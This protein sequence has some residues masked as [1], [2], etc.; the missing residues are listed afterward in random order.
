M[1]SHSFHWALEFAYRSFVPTLLVIDHVPLNRQQGY[2]H[3]KS[4]RDDG[5]QNLSVWHGNLAAWWMTKFSSSWEW[6]F[7]E[8]SN[9]W[10]MLWW[11]PEWRQI[12]KW[13]A[14]QG[15]SEFNWCWAEWN[16]R[17][18]F[19]QL[20]NA[21]G[22]LWEPCIQISPHAY[23]IMP[24]SSHSYISW[25]NHNLLKW[26]SQETWN[27]ITESIEYNEKFFSLFKL[28]KQSVWAS[29][30]IQV[31]SWRKFLKCQEFYLRWFLSLCSS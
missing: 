23:S 1:G 13:R 5:R 31:E 6:L 14:L 8:L 20:Y 11:I 4:A 2:S 18:Q 29:G 30:P 17:G 9:G 26:I 3:G 16:L 15:V 7:Y 12:L 27:E 10:G 24:R 21:D 28:G 22:W 19:T 25:S